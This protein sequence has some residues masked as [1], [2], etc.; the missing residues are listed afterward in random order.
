MR[1]FGFLFCMAVGMFGCHS[2]K[3]EK[4]LK[5][6][7]FR[8]RHLGMQVRI[9][10]FAP[11]EAYAI[12]HAKAAYARIEA[13]E[14]I[15]SDYREDSELMQFCKRGYQQEVV[16]SK[17]LFTVLQQ[18]QSVAAWSAGAFDVTVG[19]LSKLWREARRQQRLPDSLILQTAKAQVGWQ[20]LKLNTENQSARLEKPQMQLDLGGIAKGYIAQAALKT[21]EK[22]GLRQAM[23]EIGG[24][25]A[26]GEAPPNA[27]GWKIEISNDAAQPLHELRNTVVSTSGDTEQFLFLN[28]K[29]FSHVLD[30]RTGLGLSSR[31]S[32][33][34]LSKDGAYA[35]ALSTALSV[36]N[37]EGQA[38]AQKRFRLQQVWIR[39]LP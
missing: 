13:L 21:L 37:G 38:E 18:G 9:V 31:I 24:E 12:E 28:G 30:P 35:D 20:S 23:V 36:L 25:I 1:W 17:D 6:Y 4:N 3:L 26:L 33:T 29:R 7:E 15:M 16:L 22:A 27:K 11:D 32:V 10:L 2:L 34:V 14:A 5:Q 8:Q 39:I 19:G